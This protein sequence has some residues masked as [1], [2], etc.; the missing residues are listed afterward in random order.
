VVASFT[1]DTGQSVSATSKAT[2]AIADAAP[3]VTMP[4]I[5][6]MRGKARPSVVTGR[7]EG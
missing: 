1:D 2:A 4:V 6:G 7:R 5:T 3:T